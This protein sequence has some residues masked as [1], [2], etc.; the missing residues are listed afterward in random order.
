VL[1]TVTENAA[2]FCD[3]NNAVIHRVVG[4]SFVWVAQYGDWLEGGA[5]IP[6]THG[7]PVGRAI[8]NRQTIHVDDLLAEI[9][10]EYP[11]VRSQRLRRVL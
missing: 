8:L 11:D 7:T 1:N 5:R 2:R 4:D 9:D 6:I 10:T 3:A